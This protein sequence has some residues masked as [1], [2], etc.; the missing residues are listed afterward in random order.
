MEPGYY[1]WFLYF[2]IYAYY[3]MKYL[4][5]IFLLK[6]TKTLKRHSFYYCI[7]KNE[8]SQKIL[9]FS[10][11]NQHSRQTLYVISDCNTQ[12]CSLQKLVISLIVVFFISLKRTKQ[13]WAKWIFH[14]KLI[15]G[16]KYYSFKNLSIWF[17]LCEL[18]LDDL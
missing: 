9:N 15:I 11:Q 10:S 4:G 12:L 2:F 17:T 14:W 3:I 5:L 18:I 8:T 1:E 16:I 13:F 7:A 6:S